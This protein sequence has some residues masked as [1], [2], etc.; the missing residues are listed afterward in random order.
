MSRIDA[1]LRDHFR[2]EPEPEGFQQRI[3]A[4]LRAGDGAGEPLDPETVRDLLARLA[5]EATAAGVSEV[6][7]GGGA[8][9]P[10]GIAAR[11]FAAQARSELREYWEGRRAFFSVPV[12]LR[13]APP[14]QL[15]VLDAAV[16]I[17]FGGFRSY[18]WVARTIGKPK[19]MRAVG[20]ALGR[21]PVPFIVPCHRVL[22]SD[23]SL[24]GYGLGLPL[25]ERL[26]DLEMRT[27]PLEGCDS[28]RIV[29]RTGCRSGERMLPSSRVLFASLDDALSVG[30][31]PCRSCRP[32]GAAGAPP[33]AGA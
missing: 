22:R 20:T 9:H 10:A 25:K 17:P 8:A 2:P 12:D 5:V 24:G 31:R 23:G 14:F 27:P 7:L 18:A 32:A 11:R 26:L 29:C 30:Y 19:A 1:I 16:R 4:G 21:N 3:L 13:A 33:S 28:T 15:R 6:R